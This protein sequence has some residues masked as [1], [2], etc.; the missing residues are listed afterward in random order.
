MW[1]QMQLRLCAAQNTSSLHV[2]IQLEAATNGPHFS[3][4]F[5]AHQQQACEA[6]TYMEHGRPRCWHFQGSMPWSNAW[7]TSASGCGGSSYQAGRG[8]CGEWSHCLTYSEV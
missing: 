4:T 8:S 5:V 3:G 2:S 1:P 6:A 7:C